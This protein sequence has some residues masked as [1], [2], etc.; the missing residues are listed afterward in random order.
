[1]LNIDLSIKIIQLIFLVY[2]FPE[3]RGGNHCEIVFALKILA[4]TDRVLFTKIW[5]PEYSS[6]FHAL[7]KKSSGELSSVITTAWEIYYFIEYQWHMEKTMFKLTTPTSLPLLNL[8]ASTLEVLSNEILGPVDDIDLFTAFWNETG[9]LLWHLNHDDTL[10]E[11]PLLAVAL[12]NP[13]Y[14]TALDDDWYLLLGIVCDN[15]QGIY[16][17]FPDTT[18]ITQ[19]QNLIEALNHE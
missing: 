10:P 5:P 15:G 8:P 3:V 16:L 19:L 6:F 9:T 7:E 14:V 17:V 12:A 11:D 1:M 2:K 13:E 18:V 4:K